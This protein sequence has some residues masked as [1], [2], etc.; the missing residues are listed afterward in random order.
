MLIDGN[1]IRALQR[2]RKD[3]N[4][5]DLLVDK[6][7][8]DELKVILKAQGELTVDNEFKTAYKLVKDYINR[9]DGISS[10]EDLDVIKEAQK[11][12]SFILR[13]EEKLNDIEAVKAFK[14]A[15][16]GVLDEED[17]KL[18]DRVI[19]RLSELS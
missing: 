15:V 7:Y 5:Y 10:K 18:R 8:H 19:T 13:N 2:L 1:I 4:Q 3:P 6:L 17:D 12:L 16:L 9:L 14:E 11:F